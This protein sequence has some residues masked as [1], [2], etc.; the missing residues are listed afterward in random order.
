MRRRDDRVGQGELDES[1]PIARNFIDKTGLVFG[2]L[3]I[4]E[5]AGKY[6]PRPGVTI[7]FWKYACE[8]GNTGIIRSSKLKHGSIESCGCYSPRSFTKSK[9]YHGMKGTPEYRSWM[10]MKARCYRETNKSYSLYGGRGIRVCQRWMSDFSNFLSDMGRKPTKEHTLDRINVDG[11]YSPNNCRWA[12]M[13]TQC[14]NKR[15]NVTVFHMGKQRTFSELSDISGVKESTIRHRILRMGL[16]V[17]DALYS[18]RY[19][20]GIKT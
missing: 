3:L 13:L 4:T 12:T 19:K 16:P 14:R 6:F 17:S 5:Y 8:C 7:L 18:G 10:A 2:R 20:P 9:G 1:P 15:N 11:D